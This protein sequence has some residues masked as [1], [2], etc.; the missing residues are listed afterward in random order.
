MQFNSLIHDFVSPHE[1]ATLISWVTTLREKF[2]KQAIVENDH[3]R[4]LQESIN[5]F[6]VMYLFTETPV[7]RLF[8]KT[9]TDSNLIEDV[10]ALCREVQSRVKNELKYPEMD[11][12]NYLQVMW[13]GPG[14]HV[15]PHYDPSP[16]GYV[17]CRANLYLSSYEGDCLHI[18]KETISLHERD[19]YCFEPSL[20]KHWT[21]PT[22]VEQRISIC[23]GFL[24]PYESLGVDPA[25]S[26]VRFSQKVW[27]KYLKMEGVAYE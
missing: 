4:R 1:Q 7:M 14:G 11:Q 6:S 2:G 21:D 8:A 12:H 9:I 16:P 23:F 18:D 17:N 10:H 15:K 19:L 27:N 5:G 24:L 20:Y 3:L 26:R 13:M 22:T 25:S